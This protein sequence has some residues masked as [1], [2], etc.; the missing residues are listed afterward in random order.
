MRLHHGSINKFE[1][2]NLNYVNY[3]TDFGAG[4]Y[5]TSDL[6]Q[7]KKWAKTKKK[8]SKNKQTRYE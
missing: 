1:Q 4:F 6:N 8:R 2:P 3:K 7:A 5:T